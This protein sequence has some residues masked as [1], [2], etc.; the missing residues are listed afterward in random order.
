L[1]KDPY[2]LG[3]ANNKHYLKIYGEK[4]MKQWIERNH[5]PQN[6]KLAGEEALWFTQPMLLGTTRDME[7][8]AAAIRKIQQYANEL[9]N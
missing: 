8:I 2:V 3:L 7:Q 6:D 1:N 4:V 9:K 5:C